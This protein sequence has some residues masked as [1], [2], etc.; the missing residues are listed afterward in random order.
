M[1][2][3]SATMFGR[4]LTLREPKSHTQARGELKLMV[5]RNSSWTLRGSFSDCNLTPDSDKPSYQRHGLSR[6]A[7]NHRFI[8]TTSCS[9]EHFLGGLVMRNA[10]LSDI[11]Q[12]VQIDR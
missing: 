12:D 6:F 10:I 9:R 11:Q 8:F 4:E 5:I 2:R 7:G 3:S 1:F